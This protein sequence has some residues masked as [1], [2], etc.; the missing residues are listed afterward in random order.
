MPRMLSS[1]TTLVTILNLS[2]LVVIRISFL[3]LEGSKQGT[4]TEYPRLNVFQLTS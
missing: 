3:A 1:I 2:R 4:K